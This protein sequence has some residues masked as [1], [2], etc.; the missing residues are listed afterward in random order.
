LPNFV[1]ERASEI[2]SLLAEKQSGHSPVT[3]PVRPVRAKQDDGR[4][5]SLFGAAPQVVRDAV[6]DRVKAR[7]KELDVDTLSARDALQ[8]LY[9][10]KEIVEG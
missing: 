10:L 1:I 6:A 4:Q 5:Q 7:V 2:L 3:V 8:C 9:S